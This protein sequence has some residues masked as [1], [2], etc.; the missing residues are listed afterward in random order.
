MKVKGRVNHPR[1]R[2]LG[3]GLIYMG[4]C[5]DRDVIVGELDAIHQHFQ[6]YIILESL[7]IIHDHD[8]HTGTH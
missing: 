2:E 5:S 4:P 3:K 1:V 7:N 8:Q 6:C